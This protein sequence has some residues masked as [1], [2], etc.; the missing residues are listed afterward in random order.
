MALF[1]EMGLNYARI[2]GGGYGWATERHLE[3]VQA[4]EQRGVKVLLQLGS[5]YPSGDYFQFRDAWLVDHKGET[6]EENRNAWAI[7]Y[8]GK[9]WP[10]YSYASPETRARFERDFAAYLSHFGELDNIAAICLHNEP[11]LHWLRERIFDYS[12]PALAAFGKWLRER[13]G[14]IDALN[15]AWGTDYGSFAEAEPPRDEPPVANI[16]AWLDWRRANVA[17]IADFLQWEAAFARDAMPGV[18]LTTNLAGP[19]DW[20]YAWRL[21]DNLRFTRGLDIAGIDIYPG[22]WTRLFHAPYTTDLT[23]GVAQ[24]RPV[25]VLECETYGV[26]AWDHMSGEQR[27]DRLRADIW[28]YLGHGARGILLWRLTGGGEFTLTNGEF[29]P[30]VA[31][32]REVTHTARMLALERY[33]PVPAE[34]AVVVDPDSYLYLTGVKDEPPWHL[35]NAGMGMYAAAREA[36]YPVDVIFADAVRDGDAARYKALLLA[37]QVMVDGALAARLTEFVEGGGLLVAEAPFGEVDV[38]GKAMTAVPGGGL[39]EVLG[40][41]A[42]NTDRATAPIPADPEPITVTHVRRHVDMRGAEVLA[43]FGDGAPA[44]TL[45]HHGTGEAVYIA[46]TVSVPYL[47]GYGTWARPGLRDL[48]GSLL[49]DQAGIQ[50]PVRVDSEGGGP[51]DVSVLGDDRGNRLVVLTIASYR[52]DP[53]KPATDVKVVLPS[54]PVAGTTFWLFTPGAAPR[55]LAPGLGEGGAG[56]TVSVGTFGSTALLLAARDAGPFVAVAAPAEAAPGDEFEVR[57]TVI[58][59]AAGAVRGRLEML[60]P[61]SCTCSEPDV[62]VDAEPHGQ[63]IV[64]FTATAGVERERLV[65]KARLV[66]EAGPPVTSIPIDVRVAAD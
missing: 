54:A 33:K 65:L 35:D 37:Q 43:A 56:S 66:P 14:D 10:Q 52:K 27:A 25:H 16:T 39:D 21:S 45:S 11:G 47:D 6:G 5:H 17:F 24:G 38:H 61:S 49:A 57:V 59:P 51:L 42:L 12:P 13:Y 40:L 15:A 53:L 55:R 4:F 2:T 18:P 34:V 9:N 62:P 26:R 29:N 50:P 7:S 60:L 3:Q 63:S 1:H 64:R 44:V 58:N 41:R 28:T 36:G 8:S 30:R 22:S 20:W 46:G 48:L 32:M 23:R 19:L 31:A